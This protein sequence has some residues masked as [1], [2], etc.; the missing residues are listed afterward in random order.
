LV[1]S[2]LGTFRLIAGLAIGALLFIVVR[3]FLVGESA[4]WSDLANAVFFGFALVLSLYRPDFL[5]ALCWLGLVSIFLNTLDEVMLSTGET[6]QPY[7]FLLPL[8]VL[9]GALL[10]D[11]WISLVAFLGVHAIF[12]H[13]WLGCSVH[14]RHDVLVMTN[15]CVLTF[16]TAAASLGVWVRHRQLLNHLDL[17]AEDLR[18]EVDTRLRLHA[19]IVHDIG[20]PLTVLVNAVAVDDRSLIKDMAE[21]I[22]AI[23]EST[24]GLA[25]GT[26]IECADLTFAEICAYL[27][28]VFSA[29]LAKKNQ[30][31][32]VIGDPQL[33]VATDLT[34]LCNSVLSNALNNAIKFSPRGAVIEIAAEATGTD[35]RIAVNDQGPGLPHDVLVRGPEGWRYTSRQGSE[36]EKGSGYGLRIAALCA[37][38]LGGILEIRNRVGGGASVS[39]RLPCEA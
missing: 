3:G 28:V 30:T 29:R 13:T 1:R 35:V 31:M 21:R 22:C 27:K 15:L 10:A 6:C 19:L 4:Q 16:M 8:L 25:E 11:V 18:R 17:Q 32:I 5:R 34:I 39:V 26:S 38:R 2:R 12:L 33:S 9:Y 20:N 24:A 14:D 36:G 7:L 23:I 37:E